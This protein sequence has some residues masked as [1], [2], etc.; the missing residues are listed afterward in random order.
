M[1]NNLNNCLDFL[2]SYS[3]FLSKVSK[4]SIQYFKISKD[5][6]SL[7]TI[8][9]FSFNNFIKYIKH[10]F[11]KKYNNVFSKIIFGLLKFSSKVSNIISLLFII[12]FI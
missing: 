12:L 5:L 8:P 1:Q 4:Y 6:L 11:S 10:S 2:S 7:L 3:V 9:F